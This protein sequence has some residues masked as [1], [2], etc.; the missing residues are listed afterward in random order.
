MLNVQVIQ[1]LLKQIR[2][3]CINNELILIVHAEEVNRKYYLLFIRI[4]IY[5][6]TLGK[7]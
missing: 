2:L 6:F 1:P 5:H 4:V 3:N 7:L